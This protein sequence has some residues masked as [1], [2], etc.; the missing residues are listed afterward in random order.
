MLVEDELVAAEHSVVHAHCGYTKRI[1]SD[2][3][4]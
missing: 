1:D 2:G 4:C 3:Y